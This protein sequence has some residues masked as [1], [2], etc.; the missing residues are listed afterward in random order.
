MSGATEPV[1]SGDELDWDALESHLRAH[2][3]LPA[4]RPEVRQFTAGR[5]NLTYLVDV[6][7]FRIV[8]RR[9]PRGALA[10]G[11]HD[12]AREYKVL[13]RLWAVYPPAPRALHFCADASVIGAPFIVIEHR[14]GE[15]VRDHIPPSMTHHPEVGRRLSLALIDTMTT[16]HAVDVDDAGLN[17]LGRPQGYA[18]RQ[19][20]G[21]LDRWRRAAP[22]D[23]PAAMEVV[24]IELA[25]SLP[26]PQ[27][28]SI[29]HNDL[30]L[31]NCQFQA[32]D[33][34]TVSS[35][36]DW[37]MATLGDPLFDLANLLVATQG[38]AVQT[39]SP[40][41]VIARYAEQSGAD[42]SGLAWYE[43]FARWRSAVVVQQLYNRHVRGD[44]SDDRLAAL[45]ALV[46]AIAAD[47]RRALDDR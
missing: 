45:G 6:D 20:S 8:V 47:A 25:E 15:I 14:A 26:A 11:A 40:E 19:V 18:E 38:S 46:P 7:G 31:D 10:P 17:D 33:P 39:A 9:P 30:K 32:D 36:F 37:D 22:D 35:V 2:L 42:L 24:A 44:S 43:A 21:W 4:G 28:V 12:I 13:S 5:A 23:G 27:R 34:D 3:D 1:R 41:E 29:V 16:L